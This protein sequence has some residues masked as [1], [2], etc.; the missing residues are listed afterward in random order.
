VRM[1]VPGFLVGAATGK[2]DVD[3]RLG[4]RLD[5]RHGVFSAKL[6]IVAH[7]EAEATDEAGKQEFAAR[8]LAEMRRIVVPSNGFDDIAHN[9]LRLGCAETAFGRSAGKQH[10]ALWVQLLRKPFGSL[11][12]AAW[13]GPACASPES[14]PTLW[15]TLAKFSEVS[16]ALLAAGSL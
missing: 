13:F 6:E 12:V 5:R 14:D 8:A 9:V 4:L 2:E 15:R 11:G 1:R 3:E 10:L 16:P 7:G